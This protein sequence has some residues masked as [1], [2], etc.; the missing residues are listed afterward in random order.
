M[1]LSSYKNILPASIAF[2]GG[3]VFA[4]G[5]PETLLA[6]NQVGYIPIDRPK[7]ERTQ[8]GGSRLYEKT[9]PEYL[10]RL[11]SQASFSQTFVIRSCTT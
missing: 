5:Q 4:V 11:M 1:L 2:V 10:Q 3:M 8:G 6:N 7:P 9:R